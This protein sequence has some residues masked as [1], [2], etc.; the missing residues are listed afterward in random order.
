ML[1]MTH[2]SLFA[3]IP[4]LDQRSARETVQ[5]YL[6]DLIV[7]G[8]LKA[9]D[10]LPSESDLATSFGVSRVVIREAMKVLEA[11]GLVTISQGKGSLVSEASSSDAEA[12]I[13]LLLARGAIGLEDIWQARSV[14]DT[15]IAE[16]AALMRTPEQL[17]HMHETLSLWTDPNSDLDTLIA[18]DERFHELLVQATGNP[19]LILLAQT[20]AN[21]LHNARKLSLSSPVSGPDIDGHRMILEAVRN[22]DPRAAHDAME[23]HLQHFRRDL[24][25]I[26]QVDGEATETG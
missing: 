1:S 17:R 4:Q 20:T 15:G 10:R 7:N 18:A 19:V 14:L 16:L 9:G 5:S 26:G 8:D 3:S 24:V 23:A 12:P 25:A 2:R 13:A 11:L 21:L 6:T 22:K